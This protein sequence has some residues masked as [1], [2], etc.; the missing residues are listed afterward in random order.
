MN[1]N[2]DVETLKMLYHQETENLK[3]LKEELDKIRRKQEL[4]TNDLTNINTEYNDF[5]QNLNEIKIEQSVI[6]KK[7]RNL[8]ID[9]RLIGYDILGL[10]KLIV[11]FIVI[12]FDVIL[13]SKIVIGS[14][15]ID[16]AILSVL[17]LASGIV[18]A[19]VFIGKKVSKFLNNKFEMLLSKFENFIIKK[20]ENN[21]QY[22]ELEFLKNVALEILEQVKLEKNKLE[23]ER[24]SLDLEYNNLKKEYD[25]K[26]GIV[27]YLNKQI[28][29][30]EM[31]TCLNRVLSE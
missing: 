27:E 18:G 11:F 13:L 12:M 1:E 10:L 21:K 29:P 19:E 2:M 7:Y 24:N 23:T 22:K 4:Y 30:T 25:Y 16:K 14:I 26:K 20:R 17:G 31:T 15:D 5:E 8:S 28:N 6:V 3:V 9:V